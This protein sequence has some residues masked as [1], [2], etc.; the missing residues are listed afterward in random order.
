MRVLKSADK[1]RNAEN[2]NLIQ[3]ICEI[4]QLCKSKQQ[5]LYMNTMQSQIATKVNFSKKKS[6]NQSPFTLIQGINIPNQHGFLAQ[7]RILQNNKNATNQTIY[8]QSAQKSNSNQNTEQRI[9]NTQQDL[10]VT[11]N[12]FLTQSQILKSMEDENQISI[13]PFVPN[14]YTSQEDNEG[15]NSYN[16]IHHFDSRP[17]TSSS[18]NT[19][20]TNY[21]QKN[22]TAVHMSTYS[23]EMPHYNIVTQIPEDDQN[24]LNNNSNTLSASVIDINN[25]FQD[26]SKQMSYS[27]NQKSTVGQNSFRAGKNQSETQEKIKKLRMRSHQSAMRGTNTSSSKKG[28]QIQNASGNNN[29]VKLLKMS[30]EEVKQK[31]KQAIESIKSKLA[32]NSENDCVL[33]LKTQPHVYQ[34]EDYLNNLSVYQPNQTNCN[35]LSRKK[36]SCIL[37]DSSLP[38]KPISQNN[39]MS[40]TSNQFMNNTHTHG[41]SGSVEKPAFSMGGVDNNKKSINQNISSLCI[42]PNKSYK[43]KSYSKQLNRSIDNENGL[44]FDQRGNRINDENR[45]NLYKRMQNYNTFMRG[46]FAFHKLNKQKKELCNI[47]N[48]LYNSLLENYEV[49]GM[50]KSFNP[51]L[52]NTQP[53]KRIYDADDDNENDSP[54]FNHMKKYYNKKYGLKLQQ[55]EN[56]KIENQTGKNRSFHTN[57][58]TPIKRNKQLKIIRANEI[59]N[60]SQSNSTNQYEKYYSQ[61]AT[62]NEENKFSK[63]YTENLLNQSCTDFLNIC[64]LNDFSQM[65]QEHI[66]DLDNDNTSSTQNSKKQQNMTSSY[67]LQNFSQFSSSV[68]NQ[69]QQAKRYISVGNKQKKKNDIDLVP[70]EN[71]YNTKV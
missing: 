59:S 1:K 67:N 41:F 27:T 13:T 12:N 35:F 47:S 31:S 5:Q 52:Q 46:K 50:L 51:S 68:I 71:D 17:Q 60:T 24:N 15:M 26:C 30:E 53:K 66:Q 14:N 45:N 29:F 6:A 3:Q 34:D 16:L 28:S 38:F 58:H 11:E 56:E 70:W 37:N 63:I 33:V 48:V 32:I 49:E 61:S 4:D 64:N 10:A 23:Q 44:K 19:N 54:D 2:I 20:T 7:K 8:S 42:T 9:M 69:C 21:T 57:T 22:D 36:N 62:V 43:G 65:Q 18:S 40:K 39:M 55:I 25:C